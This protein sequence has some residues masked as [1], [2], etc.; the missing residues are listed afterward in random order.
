MRENRHMVSILI[1]GVILTVYS[2]TFFFIFRCGWKY[3]IILSNLTESFCFLKQID[4]ETIDLYVFGFQE[5]V[6]LK[7][8]QVF[9]TYKISQQ[10]NKFS[11]STIPCVHPLLDRWSI[12]TLQTQKLGQKL[13]SSNSMPN[14]NE[15]YIT[16]L[17][18]YTSFI[19]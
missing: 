4:I 16:H 10:L 9:L 1:S 13:Y 2:S 6:R 7:P 3:Q 12:Q 11:N 14:D 15:K 19:S 18:F 5:I 17:R 8:E